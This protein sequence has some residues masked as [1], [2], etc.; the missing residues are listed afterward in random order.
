MP[1]NYAE[2]NRLRGRIDRNL[3]TL[4]D[5]SYDVDG[6]LTHRLGFE[7]ERRNIAGGFSIVRRKAKEESEGGR[8]GVCRER[9]PR[10]DEDGTGI[11]VDLLSGCGR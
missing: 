6:V 7:Q 9:S 11:V 4:A 5:A 2:R 10:I 3:V 1:F 8:R